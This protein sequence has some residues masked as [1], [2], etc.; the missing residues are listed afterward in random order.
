MD[1]H[2]D[3]AV[4]DESVALASLSG[5]LAQVVLQQRCGQVKPTNSTRAPYITA[6]SSEQTTIEA[7]GTRA[8][9]GHISY[10]D[11]SSHHIFEIWR[12]RKVADRS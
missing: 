4:G 8:G 3:Q 11:G 1:N 5:T 12:V 6:E 2:L 10:T 9:V 7:G